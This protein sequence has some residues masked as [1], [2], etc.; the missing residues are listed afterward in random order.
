MSNSQNSTSYV[1][2]I[3]YPIEYSYGSTEVS[4]FYPSFSIAYLIYSTSQQQQ[5]SWTAAEE[6]RTEHSLRCCCRAAYEVPK[7]IEKTGTT[8]RTSTYELLLLLQQLAV[9]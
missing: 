8:T 4:T 2:N 6:Q 1:I 5:C 7:N 9:K 3:L